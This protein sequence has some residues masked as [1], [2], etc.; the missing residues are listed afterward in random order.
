M[1]AA[2]PVIVGGCLSLAVIVGGC[3]DPDRWR[4][5]HRWRCDRWRCLV[6]MSAEREGRR[7]S[8]FEM[9]ARA[10]AWFLS[11]LAVPDIAATMAGRWRALD[12]QTGSREPQPGPPSASFHGSP[13]TP[14]HISA[15]QCGGW[16]RS[17]LSAPLLTFR[18]HE[19]ELPKFG[20]YKQ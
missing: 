16:S 6:S 18:N 19:F 5:C 9:G 3:L 17:S 8:S 11:S 7:V 12:S 2:V 4:G 13:G 15:W 14:T 10:S 1:A 20:N